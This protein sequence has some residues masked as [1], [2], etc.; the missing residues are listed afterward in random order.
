LRDEYRFLGAVGAWREALR[1]QDRP[2]LHEE[3]REAAGL[4]RRADVEFA[5][6]VHQIEQSRFEEARDTLL[7]LL[8]FKPDL[9]KAHGRL[10]TVY[11]ILGEKELARRH[12]NEVFRH[13][14]DDSYGES[15][16][17]WLAHLAG[18]PQEAL[19]HYDRAAGVEPWNARNR[20]QIALALAALHRRG[21]AIAA[22]RRV[23][24]IDPN[25]AE[26]CWR[27]SVAL[28]DDGL[29]GEAIPCAKRAVQLS[30]RQ[31]LDALMS[32]SR[33]LFESGERADAQEVIREAL[34]IAQTK[35][36]NRVAEVRALERRINGERIPKSS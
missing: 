27:L 8:E 17:G 28:C 10:G 1:V 3:L 26:A 7:A 29:P 6:A 30:R 11:A 36:P 35:N 22:Y 23:L 16:L 24:E 9:A 19:E 32:L 13:D 5:R 20:F 31:D 21:D 4:H 15:M 34:G 33:A 25:H 18:N 12:L 2:E 14:P